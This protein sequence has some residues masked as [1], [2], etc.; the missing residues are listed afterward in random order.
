MNYNVDTALELV[1][2]TKRRHVLIEDNG[3]LIAVVSIG[4]LLYHILESKSRVIEQLEHYIQ[5]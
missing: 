1:I 2:Q 3:E 4:D 5:C